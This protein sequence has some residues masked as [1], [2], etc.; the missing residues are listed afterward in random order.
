MILFASDRNLSAEMLFESTEAGW[1]GKPR[2][3]KVLRTEVDSGI[4]VPNYRTGQHE[5]DL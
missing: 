3:R 2:N 1:E 4:Q 5:E